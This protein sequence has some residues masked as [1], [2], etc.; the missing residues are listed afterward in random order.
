MTTAPDRPS[1]PCQPSLW[2]QM[3]PQSLGLFALA[4]LS[5]LAFAAWQANGAA[6]L[7]A[8]AANGLAWCF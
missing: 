4:M 2:K 6:L 5:G 3:L 8:L 1:N 7:N